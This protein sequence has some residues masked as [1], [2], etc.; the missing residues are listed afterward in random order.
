[1]KKQN[2]KTES[3]NK[4]IIL[5]A[6]TFVL[7]IFLISILLFFHVM[8]GVFKIDNHEVEPICPGKTLNEALA[9]NQCNFYK[10]VWL[11]Q[12]PQYKSQIEN[13]NCSCESSTNNQPK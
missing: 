6:K 3:Y 2:N 9:K 1:M 7:I 8:L 13:I 5:I 12:Y 10:V 4:T 11:N